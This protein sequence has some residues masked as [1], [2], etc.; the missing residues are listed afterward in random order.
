M[1]IFYSSLGNKYRCSNVDASM[2]TIGS[3]R[4][5][6]GGAVVACGTVLYLLQHR[7]TVLKTI[8]KAQ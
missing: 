3:S 8:P 7:P 1:V 6:Q 4:H 5:L 2:V